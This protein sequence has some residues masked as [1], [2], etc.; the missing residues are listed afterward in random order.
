[1]SAERGR[2]LRSD[3]AANRDRLLAAATAAVKRD[4][5]KVRWPRWPPRPASG[6][7]A[8]PALPHSRGPAVGA[9][10]QVL[11]AG[12]VRRP[13]CRREPGARAHRAAGL[14]GPHDPPPRRADLPLHGGP[15]TMDPHT[16]ALRDAISQALDRVLAR[17]RPRAP[18][19]PTS[20][21]A[22]S[23]SWVRCSLTPSRTPPTGT[24]PPAARPAST[25]SAWPRPRL[26]PARRRP[27]PR[28]PGS[29][30]LC[31]PHPLSHPA[32]AEAIQHVS[33]T[34]WRHH[35]APTR[36]MAPSPG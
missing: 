33:N 11:R 6:S 24:R 30:L 12:P 21:L 2:P 7:H 13:P 4:G 14:P 3:A 16:V 19:R 1:M 9:G 20:P 15:V 31:R 35:P 17:A 27:D 28:R 8:V 32:P 34:R 23:S 36:V 26:R 10:N 5:E 22:T 18:S 29:R 25:S